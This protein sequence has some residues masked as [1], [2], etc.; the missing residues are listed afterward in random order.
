L[1]TAKPAPFFIEM[2]D[3]LSFYTDDADA[4]VDDYDSC[5]SGF[6]FF[7]SIL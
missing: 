2:P 7:F 3:D 4:A 6:F 5:T 1:L